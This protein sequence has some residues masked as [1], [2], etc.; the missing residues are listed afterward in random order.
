MPRVV[1]CRRRGLLLVG[2][3]LGVGLLTWF[4]LSSRSVATST[5]E[6]AAFLQQHWRVPIPLQ[7][8]PPAAFSPLEASLQ[9]RDCGVCHPQQYQDWQSSLHSQSMSPGVYGQLL[10]MEATDPA[11]Y[12]LCSTCHAPLSEQLPFLEEAGTYRPNAAFDPQLQQQGLVCAACHVR[13][14][15]R[16]G[17][18]RRTDLP[19]LPPEASLPHGGF[20]AHVAFERSE[21]CRS[22]HQFEPGDFALNG[23]LI[24]NTYEEWRQSPYAR[25]GVQCQH[26]HMP[27]RRHLWRG[28][29]DPQ[30]VKQALTVAVTLNAAA[31]QP[32]DRLQAVITVTNSGAGHFL[33]TYVTP[34]IFVFASLLDARGEVLEGSTQQAVIGR[35]VTLDLSQ[36]LYDTRIPPKQSRAFTYE[37]P[38]PPEAARLQVRLVVHPDHFYE[39]FFTAMLEDGSEGPGRAYLEEALRRTQRSSFVVFDQTFPLR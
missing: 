28:I 26:C 39:R 12:T 4:L 2:L 13:S 14:H 31:Y 19:P 25:Q 30:M 18:P 11:T 17:P 1:A 9:P 7:G 35:E 38:V 32:G 36:E 15:R 3:A 16:F 10:A 33:P 20:V 34:K 21:F 37:H 6:V 27:E 22:C 8:P 24:E 23:K 5:P 29:H